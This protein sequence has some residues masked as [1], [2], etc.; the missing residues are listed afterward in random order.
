MAT[1]L[2]L[3]ACPWTEDAGDHLP[4]V[5]E[6]RDHVR[7]YFPLSMN[8]KSAEIKPHGRLSYCIHFEPAEGVYATGPYIDVSVMPLQEVV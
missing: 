2:D 1:D 7:G 5:E 8:G 6:I 3:I 4:M